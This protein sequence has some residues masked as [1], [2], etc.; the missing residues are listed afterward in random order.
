M[1]Q[2]NTKVPVWLLVGGSFNPVTN[3]HLRMFELAKYHVDNKLTGFEV[4]KGIISPVSDTYGEKKNLLPAKVRSDMVQL[5]LNDVSEELSWVTV[6]DWEAS[7]Q[8]WTR[9][10]EVMRHFHEKMME[11]H[12]NCDGPKPQ[13]KLL[14]GADLLESFAKPGLWL[15]EDLQE[16]VGKFGVIVVTRQG[17]DPYHFVDQHSILKMNQSNVTIIPEKLGGTDISSTN[18]RAAIASGSP[19]TF[20]TQR[21]VIKFIKSNNLYCS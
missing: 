9:L 3:A 18:I 21:S 13:L 4:T 15:D 7:Q 10:L 14:C 20:A 8:G 11:E 12:E 17:S 19:I 2:L 5:A 16:I 6:D 1:A